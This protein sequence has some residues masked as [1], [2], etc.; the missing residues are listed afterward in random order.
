MMLA[1]VPTPANRRYVVAACLPPHSNLVPK[2]QAARIS[3]Q[4][5]EV[6][7][8]LTSTDRMAVAR[9]RVGWAA[10]GP[11]AIPRAITGSQEGMA[12]HPDDTGDIRGIGAKCRPL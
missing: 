2:Q 5:A 9:D 10:T 8:R 4:P 1:E 7:A 11:P 3:C 12:G 6:L